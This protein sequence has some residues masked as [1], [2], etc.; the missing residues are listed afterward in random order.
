[1]NPA[2]INTDYRLDNRTQIIDSKYHDPS[3]GI[4]PLEKRLTHK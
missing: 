2:S 4:G 1:M 3:K